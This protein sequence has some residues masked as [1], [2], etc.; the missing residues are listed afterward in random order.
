MRVLL[1]PV[2]LVS[3]ESKGKKGGV[4]M[5]TT[6]KYKCSNCLKEFYADRLKQVVCPK[7]RKVVA[8]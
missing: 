6:E 8:N 3:K 2:R 5:S 7:C 1:D 4:F